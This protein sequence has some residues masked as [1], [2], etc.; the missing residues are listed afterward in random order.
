MSFILPQSCLSVSYTV[1][2]LPLFCLFVS[3]TVPVFVCP[4][5]VLCVNADLSLEWIFLPSR[6]FV[7]KLLVCDEH[8]AW[9]LL[10]CD[11]HLAWKLLVCEE[12]L[13]WKLLDCDEHLA[14]KLAE[15]LIIWMQCMSKDEHDSWNGSIQMRCQVCTAFNAC[16]PYPN[17]CRRNI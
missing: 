1:L 16:W 2:I 15:E 7:W 8:L 12:H 3:D 11:E 13:A 9:K 4:A 6:H 14:W 5:A 10:V 17:A